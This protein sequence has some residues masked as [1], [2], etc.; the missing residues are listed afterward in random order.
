MTRMEC[1][2]KVFITQQLEAD[3]HDISFYNP[4]ETF[5]AQFIISYDS[6]KMDPCEFLCFC[7][8]TRDRIGEYLI[9]FWREEIENALQT[10]L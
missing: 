3:I 2:G 9:L 4:L 5:W 1:G 6:L 10:F 7:K 8:I